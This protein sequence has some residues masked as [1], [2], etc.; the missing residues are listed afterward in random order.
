[1]NP[2]VN[3]NPG[4]TEPSHSNNRSIFKLHR[5]QLPRIVPR[6]KD[7]SVC[8]VSAIQTLNSISAARDR[9]RGPRPPPWGVGGSQ[10]AGRGGVDQQLGG[11]SNDLA[12][13]YDSPVSIRYVLQ[14]TKVDMTWM[15]LV[16]WSPAVMF[17]APSLGILFVLKLSF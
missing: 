2:Q 15:D 7:R 14:N 3:Q 4:S 1:M 8:I 13:K 9:G 10:G 12:G 17:C 16:A 5:K 11:M 6:E